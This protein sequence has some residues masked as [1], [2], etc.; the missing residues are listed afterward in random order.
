[1]FIKITFCISRP[2]HERMESPGTILYGALFFRI[3][4]EKEKVLC[5]CKTSTHHG[6]KDNSQVRIMHL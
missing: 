2:V 3:K 5:V 4:P 6:S 1:M